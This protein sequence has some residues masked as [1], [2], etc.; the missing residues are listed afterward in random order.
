MPLGRYDESEDIAN[1]LLFLASD[2]SSFIT[3]AQSRIDD[4]MGAS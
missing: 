3:G 4:G 2:E 1:I